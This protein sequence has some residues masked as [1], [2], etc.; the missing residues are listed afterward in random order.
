MG[1]I[2]D[3]ILVLI[4]G[5]NIFIGYKK[6]L[7]NVAFNILAFLI[8]I[9]LTIV[10]FKPVSK[11]II[12]NTQIE[13]KIKEYI[14]NNNSNKENEPENQEKSNLISKYINAKMKE[15]TDTIKNEV[16]GTV[17][18][19]VSIK[20]IEIITGILLFILIRII[21]I[22]LKFLFEAISELP[23]IK[24]FNELGGTLYGLMKGLIIIY[25]IFTIIFIVTS[26]KGSNIVV[27]KIEES[28][29]TK[30]LYENNLIVNYCL[31]DKSLL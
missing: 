26:I 21:L 16:I 5:L 30:F 20:I 23:I 19:V 9:I 22:F 8:A 13:N 27:D 12:N 18:D 24:Q 14:I 15:T 4:I 25:L 29:V 6:G 10:L 28:Y 2:I 7:I 17:A 31:L 11:L 1:I 3:A